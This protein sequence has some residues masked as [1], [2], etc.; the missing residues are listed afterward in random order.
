MSGNLANSE[1]NPPI[2]YPVGHPREKSSL[3]SEKHLE[4]LRP[5][6]KKVIQTQIVLV[7]NPFLMHTIRSATWK[8]TQDKQKN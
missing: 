1:S 5:S 4:S 2:P 6:S 7:N 3:L 8:K